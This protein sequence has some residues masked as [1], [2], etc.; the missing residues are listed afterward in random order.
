MKKWQK[1]ADGREM[2]PDVTATRLDWNSELF[3]RR[4]SS[5]IPHPPLFTPS[6]NKDNHNNY[7]KILDLF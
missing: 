6:L 2:Q 5:A 3:N 4:E 1:Q 7:K